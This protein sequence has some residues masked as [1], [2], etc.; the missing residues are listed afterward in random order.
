MSWWPFRRR[1]ARNSD[2]GKASGAATRMVQGRRFAAGVPYVLP[3]DMQE[4]NRLDF[5]HFMLRQV[6]RG[7]FEAP[8]K[9]PRDVLDV[10][11]GTGR[12]A[13]ELALLWPNTNV[14]GLDVVPPPIEAGANEQNIRPPNYIF[15]PGN[16]L[17]GLPFS[18]ASF[19][20]VHQRMLVGALPRDRWPGVVQEILRVTRP[21]GWIELVEAGSARGGGPALDALNTWGVS[22][23]ATRGIDIAMGAQIGSMLQ[24]AGAVNIVAHEVFIPIGRR[25]GRVGLMM[26]ANYFSALENIRPLLLNL[27]LTD[28]ATHTATLA[29]ARREVAQSRCGVI[30]YVALGQRRA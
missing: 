16:V 13:L 21:G 26:E 12:W 4:V 11:T 1:N 22:A 19:D 2:A 23:A 30:Y 14:I 28:E 18:D 15:V 17:E 6:R 9:E 10:G 7:N 20:Y 8:V 24:T 25:G 5:Q 29:Q 3:K 27:G